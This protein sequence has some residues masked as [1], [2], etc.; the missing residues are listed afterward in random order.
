MAELTATVSKMSLVLQHIQQENQKLR[1]EITPVINKSNVNTAQ[2]MDAASMSSAHSSGRSSVNG[3]SYHNKSYHKIRIDKWGLEFDGNTKKL[4]VEDFVFRVERLQK[5]YNASWE[6]VLDNF[7]L[8]VKGVAEKCYWLFIQTNYVS[9]WAT[10]KEALLKQYQSS[11]SSFELMSDMVERKQQPGEEIDA[12]FFAMTQMRSRLDISMPE[13]EMI[14]MI[15][16]NLR[17]DLKSKVVVNSVEDLRRE[18]VEVE[19]V[20][21]KKDKNNPQSAPINR[22]T[23]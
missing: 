19:K 18:C 21:G 5:K 8:F 11:R 13:R 7:H 23:R 14:R 3:E 15:K 4:A 6:E 10:L 2:P 16:K 1:S 20:F 12:F 17:D 9:E 22:Y